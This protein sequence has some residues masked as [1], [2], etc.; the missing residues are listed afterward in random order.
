[1]RVISAVA[2]LL[3]AAVSAN[4]GQS[5]LMGAGTSTCRQFTTLLRRYPRQVEIHY[6][7]WAQGFMSGINLSG[8]L[9]GE[10][11]HDF[12][13]IPVRR[14]RKMVR[15]YCKEHPRAKYMEGVAYLYSQL[16]AEAAESKVSH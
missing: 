15:N 11:P 13:S 16:S 5:E 3:S 14:Q 8:M 12:E 7:A 1:M 10:S 2:L 9:Q 6:F 4:A